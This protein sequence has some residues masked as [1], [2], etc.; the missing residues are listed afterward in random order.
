MS[1]QASQQFNLNINMSSG[2]G[3]SSID[4]SFLQGH[5]QQFANPYNTS[6]SNPGTNNNIWNDFSTDLQT[7]GTQSNQ[8]GEQTGQPS[9]S[10]PVMKS[11]EGT[12][13]AAGKRV[14]EIED[15]GPSG[16]PPQKKT[17]G[18]EA[19]SSGANVAS[20]GDQDVAD[21]SILN[22]FVNE[23]L[24]DVPAASGSAT[25]KSTRYGGPRDATMD[26]SLQG[27]WGAG[28]GPHGENS[29]T[30]TYTIKNPKR[31]QAMLEMMQKMSI[32]DRESGDERVAQEQEEE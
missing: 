2:A 16:Q 21:M 17:A 15:D 9:N 14:L 20:A 5:D 23:A 30:H 11:I 29:S 27:N 19:S 25:P 12:S 32:E 28:R 6:Q 4:N 31:A 24:F 1:N 7:F 10:N 8:A 3:T 13:S 22:D 18:V 26:S